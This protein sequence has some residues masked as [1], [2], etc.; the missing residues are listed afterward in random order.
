MISTFKKQLQ[1]FVEV[2]IEELLRKSVRSILDMNYGVTTG[3]GRVELHSQKRKNCQFLTRNQLVQEF[4]QC[5]QKSLLDNAALLD[6]A[7]AAL[8]EKIIYSKSNQSF[9]ETTLKEYVVKLAY[10]HAHEDFER[11]VSYAKNEK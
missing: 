1:P 5:L 2:Y 7:C 4:Q 10:Q 11:A 6:V 3:W 9:V 8:H